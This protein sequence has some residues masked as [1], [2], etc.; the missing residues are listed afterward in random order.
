MALQW[1]ITFLDDDD[2]FGQLEYG[3]P[4][5]TLASGCFFVFFGKWKILNSYFGF[6]MH[7]HEMG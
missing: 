6:V 4:P 3:S 5:W 2:E 1:R 7:A